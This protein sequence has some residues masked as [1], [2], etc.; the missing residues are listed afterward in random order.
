LRIWFLSYYSAR[1]FLGGMY[2]WAADE[3][4]AALEALR[5]GA[6][7]CP[8][9]HREITPACRFEL[10]WTLPT[11]F[12]GRLL[13]EQEV[14]DAEGAMRRTWNESRQAMAAGA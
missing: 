3:E 11:G 6:P 2:V 8:P 7:V 14:E 9:C 12:L 10:S 13:T 1:E 5:Y 4:R